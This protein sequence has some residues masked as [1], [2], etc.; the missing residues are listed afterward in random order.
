MDDDMKMDDANADIVPTPT[1]K[2]K[3]TITRGTSWIGDGD[4]DKNKRRGFRK[5]IDVECNSHF[6]IRE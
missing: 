5:E 4:P 6:A 2:F 3:S 1:L